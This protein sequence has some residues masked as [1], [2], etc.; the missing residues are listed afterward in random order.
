VT[1]D[2]RRALLFRRAFLAVALVSW[3]M[4][5]AIAAGFH[6]ERE[7]DSAAW[8]TCFT[9]CAPASY[10]LVLGRR[11]WRKIGALHVLLLVSAV[12]AA[13]F[14]LMTIAQSS[15]RFPRL[16]RPTA[17]LPAAIGIPLFFLLLGS[18]FAAPLFSLLVFVF[19]RRAGAAT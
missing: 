5:I 11:A 10:V 19:G 15:R 4:W 18:L 2:D 9:F 7:G 8:L 14:A 1:E 3:G 17:D 16:L 12:L 13:L 6:G